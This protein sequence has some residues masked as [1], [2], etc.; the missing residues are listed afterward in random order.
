V[1]NVEYK[2]SVN[3]KSHG[4]FHFRNYVNGISGIVNWEIPVI[5]RN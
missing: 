1:Q 3:M 5:N 2:I 4:D